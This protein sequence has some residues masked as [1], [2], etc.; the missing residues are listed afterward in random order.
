M[1]VKNVLTRWKQKNRVGVT[2]LR[3]ETLN[4][5]NERW[6]SMVRYSS[7]ATLSR[8]RASRDVQTP[9]R[10]SRDRDWTARV[11]RAQPII[12]LFSHFN[13]WNTLLPSKVHQAVVRKQSIRPSK[14]MFVFRLPLALPNSPGVISRHTKQEL[15]CSSIKR[16]LWHGFNC[17]ETD[18]PRQQRIGIVSC[19]LFRALLCHRKHS[20]RN[21]CHNIFKVVF[22]SYLSYPQ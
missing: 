5:E 14:V 8:S 17:C 6:L 11:T 3:L 13:D 22:A 20:D 18:W 9:L 16:S 19:D 4:P 21:H 2:R 12:L 1:K 15:R 10:A 7:T